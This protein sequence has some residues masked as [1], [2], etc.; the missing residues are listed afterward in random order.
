MFSYSVGCIGGSRVHDIDT[1]SS[2]NKTLIHPSTPYC[3]L[4][5]FTRSQDHLYAL[6]IKVPLKQF[7]SLFKY[8]QSSLFKSPI[9]LVGKNAVFMPVLVISTCY[10]GNFYIAKIELTVELSTSDRTAHPVLHTK[11][12]TGRPAIYTPATCMNI[13]LKCQ[14]IR[15]L[16]AQLATS[17]SQLALYLLCTI[18]VVYC[19]LC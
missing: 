12:A 1:V 18:A 16:W 14:G 2:W 5:V 17:M 3:S 10:T 19:V 8:Y 4:I 15:M 11:T 13:S 6:H 9:L 7:Y